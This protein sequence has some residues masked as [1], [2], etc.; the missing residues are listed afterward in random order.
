MST[1]LSR[2]DSQRY[3]A[4]PNKPP[5][6]TFHVPI[7][8]RTMMIST[9]AVCATISD[10]DAA[11]AVARG[12]LRC[13]LNIRG[14][15]VLIPHDRVCDDDSGDGPSR[16]ALTTISRTHWRCWEDVDCRDW[17]NRWARKPEAIN[18]RKDITHV[19]KHT[20]IRWG[21][22]SNQEHKHWYDSTKNYWVANK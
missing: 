16:H 2:V 13:L 7:D 1:K 5:D 6:F 11:T 10:W 14:V 12:D 17:G 9:T 4:P 15:D 18:G 8:F 21:S 20:W 3:F 19:W 22:T